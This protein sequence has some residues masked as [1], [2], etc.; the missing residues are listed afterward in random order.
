MD[1]KWKK[2]RWHLLGT[3][4]LFAAAMWL[5]HPNQTEIPETAAAKETATAATEAEIETELP[6]STLEAK[7]LSDLYR[8]LKAK[9]FIS[10]AEILNENQSL[11]ENMIKGME[12]QIYCY[13]EEEKDGR[14]VPVMDV[15]AVEGKESGLVLLR[16]HTAFY[17]SFL[18]GKPDGEGQAVQS[19]VLDEPRYTYAEGQWKNGKMNGEGNT[20]YHYYINAPESGFIR[21]EKTGVYKDDLLDGEFVY[22]TENGGGEVLS[23]KMKAENGVTQLDDS[24]SYYQSRGE[25]MLSSEES[26]ERVYVLS[27]E[28]KNEVLWNNLITWEK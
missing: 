7:Y 9:D 21:T 13:R 1:K 23:W 15:L 25:Y 5:G 8:V 11:F 22:R 26:S 27:E 18:D 28:R 10:A 14:T 4:I 2:N 19:M 6:V 24:W 12:G 20:G 3:G 17:G 16:Y